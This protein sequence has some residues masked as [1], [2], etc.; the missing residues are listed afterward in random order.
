LVS[1]FIVLVLIWFFQDMIII[2][3]S[4]QVIFGQTL[5]AR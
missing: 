2:F 5:R 4:V 3:Q 1:F